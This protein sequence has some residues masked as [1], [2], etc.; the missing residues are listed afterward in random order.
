MI[1]AFAEN[2]SLILLFDVAANYLHGSEVHR[3]TSHRHDLSGRNGACVRRRI[4]IRVDPYFLAHGISAVLAIQIKVA[5]IRKVCNRIAVGNHMVSDDQAVIRCQRVAHRDVGVSRVSLITVG[6]EQRKADDGSESALLCLGLPETVV[7]QI[8][9][10]VQIVRSVVSRQPVLFP[11]Q[12]K[13]RPRNAVGV[14]ADRCSE[15]GRILQVRLHTVISQN[16]IDEFSVSV[17]HVHRH[18]C[19]AQIGKRGRHAI[20]IRQRIESD[21]FS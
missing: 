5:V 18:P 15:V 14:A 2:Q 11:V 4:R 12:R 1:V 21:C 6:T 3:R 9:P 16:H 17:R 10:A 13:L 20:I 7:I 19:A 8:R